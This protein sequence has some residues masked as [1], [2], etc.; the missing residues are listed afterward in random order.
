MVT[1]PDS[2]PS[3]TSFDL[4]SLDLLAVNSPSVDNRQRLLSFPLDEDGALLSL[5]QIAQVFKVE[6]TEILPIP[7]LPDRILG[8]CNWQG[9]MLWLVDLSALTGYTSLLKSTQV[10]SLIVIV[11]QV[12]NQFMGLGVRQVNDIELH[13][14][15][16][17]R[18]AAMGLFPHSL[19]PFI[20]GTLPG[21]NRAV[22]D[23][24]AIVQC[25]LWQ[26]HRSIRL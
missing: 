14:L 22:L 17:I 4:L 26:E 8:I 15:Q 10:E 18:P 16:Q 13:D 3:T 9:E 7:D 1:S 23:A 11:V 6:T 20:L 25:P 5:E 21:Y 19:M 2:S 12:N 24:N